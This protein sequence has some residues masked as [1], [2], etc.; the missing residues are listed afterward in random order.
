MAIK[1]RGNVFGMQVR[2]SKILTCAM[3]FVVGHHWTARLQ[4]A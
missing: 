4:L 3:N 2:K 1:A